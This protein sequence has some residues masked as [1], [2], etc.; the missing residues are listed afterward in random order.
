MKCLITNCLAMPDKRTE[1]L[2]RPPLCLPG[3]GAGQKGKV[4]HPRQAIGAER[5]PG[6]DLRPA[7]K[8]GRHPAVRRRQGSFKPYF[9]I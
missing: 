6:S 3:H 8:R 5:T 4:S 9:V 2:S 7:G 1:L